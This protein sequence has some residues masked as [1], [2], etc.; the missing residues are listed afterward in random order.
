MAKNWRDI[1]HK[2]DS[3]SCEEAQTLAKILF[4]GINKASIRDPYVKHIAGCENC[5]TTH[6]KMIDEMG[7]F[8]KLLGDVFD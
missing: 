3:I 6:K 8:G 2:S 7:K 4:E 5:M 1:I